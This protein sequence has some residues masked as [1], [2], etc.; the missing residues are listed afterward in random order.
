MNNSLSSDSRS[1]NSSSNGLSSQSSNSSSNSLSRGYVDTMAIGD[2]RQLIHDRLVHIIGKKIQ[3]S[4]RLD[5]YDLEYINQDCD[6]KDQQHF[7]EIYN[8]VVYGFKEIIQE[9]QDDSPKVIKQRI[10]QSKRMETVFDG[11]YT[12]YSVDTNRTK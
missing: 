3:H 9:H 8:R 7:M 2:K 11:L 12:K 4:V 10:Q 6:E 1:S 5:D